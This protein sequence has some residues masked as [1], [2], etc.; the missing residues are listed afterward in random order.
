MLHAIICIFEPLAVVNP[1][2]VC[3]LLQHEY[4]QLVSSDGRS[5]GEHIPSH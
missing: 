3:T 1:C 5:L 4:C 2:A